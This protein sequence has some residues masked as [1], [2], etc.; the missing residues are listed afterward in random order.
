MGRR[1]CLPLNGDYALL[2]SNLTGVTV[3]GPGLGIDLTTGQ[4][5]VNP[6]QATSVPAVQPTATTSGAVVCPS[7]AFACNQLFSCA[8]AQA[9][10]QAGNFSLDPNTNGVACE[11]PPLN[12]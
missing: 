6:I 7:T 5:I 4:V 3:F 8:E 1:I 9:C 12:C 10:L 2:V 11:G